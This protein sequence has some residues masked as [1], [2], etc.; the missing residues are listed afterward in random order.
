MRGFLLLGLLLLCRS[1]SPARG[2]EVQTLVE[3]FYPNNE[4]LK[5]IRM[6]DIVREL[7]TGGEQPGGRRGL[8]PGRVFHD[9]SK[10]V[11]PRGK[12]YCEEI[13][14][15]KQWGLPAARAALKSG[16][17]RT[18]LCYGARLAIRSQTPPA[19]RVA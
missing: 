10:I 19:K 4:R 14:E 18:W 11:G 3:K 2:V 9:L 13:S 12:V 7:E 1:L 16:K 8:R 5:E 6:R 15:E 17:R